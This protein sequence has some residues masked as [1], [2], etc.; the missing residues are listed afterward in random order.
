MKSA[1]PPAGAPTGEPE[2]EWRNFRV[3]FGKNKNVPLGDLTENSLKWYVENF[4]VEETY[5]KGGEQVRCSDQNLASQKAFRMALDEAAAEFG[6]GDE[7]P[8]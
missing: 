2:S 6:F 5:D 1:N 7:P 8:M 4:K 3:P